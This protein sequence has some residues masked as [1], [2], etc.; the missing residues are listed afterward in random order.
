MVVFFFF[1][2]LSLSLFLFPLAEGQTE[3][4]RG[5]EAPDIGHGKNNDK[6]HSPLC[7]V[8]F[9]EGWEGGCSPHVS[10]VELQLEEGPAL[11][12]GHV[13]AARGGG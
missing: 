9:L 5:W 4:G 10:V 12:L 7:V 1:F 3:K 6:Y 2:F 13:I 11:D 8:D